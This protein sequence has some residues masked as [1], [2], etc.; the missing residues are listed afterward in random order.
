MNGYKN[1]TFWESLRRQERL[2]EFLELVDTYFSALHERQI[3]KA[4][5]AR[6]SLNIIIVDVSDILH[7]AN[8]YPV[9]TW[10]PPPSIGGPIQKID[11][12]DNL[13]F[14]DHYRMSPEHVSDLVLRAYGVYKSNHLRSFLRTFNPFWWTLR[15]LNWVATL[16]FL[17]LGTAGFNSAQAEK[18]VLG[19][20]VKFVILTLSTIATLLTILSHLGLLRNFLDLTES[21]MNKP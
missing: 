6:T 19:R 9:I 21:M 8:I 15:I 7:A 16:P 1:I 4:N 12:V 10:T 14:L 18:S 17:L 11:L 5:K 20:L 3:E 2:N 13:F